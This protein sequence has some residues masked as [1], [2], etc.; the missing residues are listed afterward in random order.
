MRANLT[1]NYA[2]TRQK[3]NPIIGNS[4]TDEFL[5]ARAFTA[6]YNEEALDAD[7]YMAIA[8]QFSFPQAGPI[9]SVIKLTIAPYNN[10]NMVGEFS[11][12]T[13]H[14]K[15]ISITSDESRLAGKFKI[16]IAAID[17]K[18]AYESR[19]TRITTHP[20]SDID[21]SAT[22]TFYLAICA[23][24]VTKFTVNIETTNGQLVLINPQTMALESGAVKEVKVNS[25]DKWEVPRNLSL[26]GTA[27]CYVA[28]PNQQYMF[29]VNAKGN[30][31]DYTNTYTSTNSQPLAYYSSAMP[32][33]LTTGTYTAELL[34]DYN[35]LDGS[36]DKSVDTTFPIQFLPKT[37]KDKNGNYIP[38]IMFKTGSEQGNALIALKNAEGT[39]VW[40]W[41]IWVSNDAD[42][43]NSGYSTT[44]KLRVM[45]RNLGATNNVA[46]G[47]NYTYNQGMYYQWGRKDPFYYGQPH[48]AKIG[49][50]TDSERADMIATTAANPTTL[51]YEY[52][53]TSTT[54]D[55]FTSDPLVSAGNMLWGAGFITEASPLSESTISHISINKTMFDP[56]PN[57]YRMVEHGVWGKQNNASAIWQKNGTSWYGTGLENGGG[58]YL[59][60]NNAYYPAC[61]YWRGSDVSQD[62]PSSSYGWESSK[63][64]R[65]WSGSCWD[66]EST[67]HTDSGNIFA[68][69]YAGTMYITNVKCQPFNAYVKTDARP[70]R[71]VFDQRLGVD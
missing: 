9:F 29:N 31:I 54:N 51:Y 47:T 46:N 41:H 40:S 22:R 53:K 35:Y 39:I 10:S 20:T 12:T 55:W 64:L 23:G 8:G 17:N 45:D 7:N 52:G 44:R 34:W 70:V 24:D 69:Y 42:L 68:P 11:G 28:L 49:D 2:V 56:C 16:S 71:C 21:C 66:P 5:I 67:Y 18:P 50:L 38:R 15:S 37:Y 1:D 65:Y 33:D 6:D 60:D 27:N 62:S 26:Y 36:A 3:Y 48:N 19:Y 4:A 59:S 43:I 13:E 14:I 30:G 58:V 61:G 25:W 32:D 57:G 63:A